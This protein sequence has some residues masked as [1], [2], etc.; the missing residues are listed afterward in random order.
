M[1]S[2]YIGIFGTNKQMY[3]HQMNVLLN[4]IE[5]EDIYRIKK[6]NRFGLYQAE[7]KNGEVYIGLLANNSARGFRWKQ[8]Y[9][10]NDI[11]M[12]IFHT[13]IRPK[14]ISELPED[15]QVIFYNHMF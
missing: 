9:V 12:D 13:I 7:M 5:K 2:K 1:T 6:S 3:F 10:P 11:D 15:E 8:V 4:S 14:I